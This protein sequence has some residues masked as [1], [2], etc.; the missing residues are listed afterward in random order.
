MMAEPIDALP[1][2]FIKAVLATEDRRFYEH[3]G[4]DFFGLVRRNDR[5][6]PRQFRRTG[7]IDDYTAIGQEPVP[8][9]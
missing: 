7:R 1:D 2:H 5:K 9:Q 4:I 3:I 6:C 8:D